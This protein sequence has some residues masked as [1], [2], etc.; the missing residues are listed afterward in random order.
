MTREQG[1]PR[2]T[3]RE[4]LTES[5]TQFFQPVLANSEEQQRLAF[6]V[7]CDVYCHEF[8]Y[9]R[10]EDCNCG[11]ETDEYDT[12][13]VHGLVVHKPSGRVAGC[14]RV[15]PRE[16]GERDRVLPIERH[17]GHTFQHETLRPSLLSDAGICEISRL[18]VHGRFRRRSGEGVSPVGDVS[19]PDISSTERRTF[20]LV[21]VALFLVATNVVKSTERPHV[22]AMMEPRLARLLKR[23]GLEFSPVGALTDFHGRRAAHYIHVDKA[24][25]GLNADLGQLYDAISVSLRDTMPHSAG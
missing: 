22:F 8:H 14:V 7:R 11:L 5:F 12:R 9:E 19:L 1:S 4:S 25:A 24:L 18:A 20:P 23:S 17:C 21:S 3:E 2:P 10:E 13:S 15:V 16:D 6:Q